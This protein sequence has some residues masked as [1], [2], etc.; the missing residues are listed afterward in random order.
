MR[1]LMDSA[2]YQQMMD[3]KNP[4]PDCF[5]RPGEYLHHIYRNGIKYVVAHA[6]QEGLQKAK[7]ANDGEAFRHLSLHMEQLQTI[8]NETGGRHDGTGLIGDP[9]PEEVT[10]SIAKNEFIPREPTNLE[11]IGLSNQFIV[12]LILRTLY[13]KG[14]MTSGEFADVLKLPASVLSN[15]LN[16]MR[17]QTLIDIAGQ[18]AG[19]IGDSGMEYEIKPPRGTAAI[20]EALKKTEYIGPAPVPFADYV[21]GVLAQSIKGV[22]VTRHNIAQAFSDLIITDQVFGEIGPAVNAASSIF[23]FG[24]PGNGKTSVAER[25]TRLLGDDLYIPYAID[26]DGTI[27]KLYDPVVHEISDSSDSADSGPM[28]LRRTRFDQRFVKIKRPTIVVGG[29]LNLAMLDLKYN[30]DARFYEAPVHMKANGGIFMIDDFGR[31]LVRPQD[32]L[33]RW[34]VPLE[35][36]YDYMTTVKGNKFEIPF[37]VLLIFSTNL[38]PNQLADEAFLRRIK[39]KIE[40]KD[41][42]EAEWRRIWQLVCRGKRVEFNDRSIDYLLE[43]WY[44]PLNRP[45]RSC[46][47]RDLLDQIINIAKFNMER[48]CLSPDLIDAGCST[49]FVSAEKKNFG[50]KVN[51]D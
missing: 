48:P 41:P 34:I 25:I 10:P 50:A 13:N 28:L 4:S 43:K 18:R 23:L 21:E 47:P 51:M 6:L 26:V 29:E 1:F 37:E 19:N 17:K 36:R 20:E 31:Q 8:M 44:K 35:K 12:D 32:L 39:F 24:F 16:L 46:H 45:M 42:A 22:T 11:E 27:I 30:A 7:A 14:R 9:A 5:V 15:V 3:Q 49:Y 33:N 40:I 2:S 38:D